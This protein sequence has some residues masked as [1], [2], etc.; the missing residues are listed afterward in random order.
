MVRAAG[1]G[2][3]TQPST[4][5]PAACP[6]CPARAGQPAERAVGSGPVSKQFPG[7]AGPRTGLGLA[8]GG[9]GPCL[10]RGTETSEPCEDAYGYRSRGLEHLCCEESA[11]AGPV[12]SGRGGCEG[13]H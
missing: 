10:G 7:R 6:A 9:S 12:Q 11:G 1:A 2:Q 4:G 13:I 8:A 3:G 5:S